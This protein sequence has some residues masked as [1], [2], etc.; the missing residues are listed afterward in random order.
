V[1]QAE[2]GPASDVEARNR[3]SALLATIGE[4][5]GRSLDPTVTVQGIADAVVP[6][7]CDWC[8]VDLVGA[9]RRLELVARA[10]REPELAH[11][12]DELR[13]RYPPHDRREPR[14][15]IYRAIDADTT[16]VETISDEDLA[17]R[18]VDADHLALL[19]AL[20]IG[21]HVVVALEARGRVIGALSLIRRPGREPFAADEVTTA[22]AIADRTALA[23]DNARL[24]LAAQAAVE[25]RD[26]F[27]GV[28]S[29]ELR[30]PLA[31]VAGHWELLC[32]RLADR[33]R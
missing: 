21:S 29:H 27:I 4:T 1:T 5:L 8:V 13:R 10:H 26:R 30:N 12:I 20:G 31:V 2:I 25:L 6:A 9:N 14:H 24:Y 15:A 16:V 18:A 23:T 17:R 19:R 7:F 22:R 11:V 3:R 33:N 32:R 28:A